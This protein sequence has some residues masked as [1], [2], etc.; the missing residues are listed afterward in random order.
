MELY[1]APLACCMSSRIALYEAGVE[2][3]YH[4]VDTKTKRVLT[5]GSDFLALTPLGQVPVLRTDSGE[6]LIE[7]AAVLQYVADHAGGEL[8]P[9]SGPERYR[10]QQWL[11]FIGTELHKFIYMPLLDEK[12]TEGAR[13]YARENAGVRFEYL[14]SHLTGRDYLLDRF[15]VADAYLVTVLNWSA[16]AGVDLAKWPA[17]AAYYRRMLKRPSVARAVAE[18]RALYAEEQARNKAA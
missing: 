3:R 6:L 1:F 8:A 5:D 18:E 13:A 12:S 7:N 15:S 2:V 9:P 17:V 14:N 16:A 10:L 11:S 4:R